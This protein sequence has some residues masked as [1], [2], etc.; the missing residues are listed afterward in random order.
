MMLL[1]FLGKKVDPVE[2]ED[3][4]R[5]HPEVYDVAVFGKKEY[6]KMERKF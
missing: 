3:V 6:G 5:A 2:V 4:L 1:I